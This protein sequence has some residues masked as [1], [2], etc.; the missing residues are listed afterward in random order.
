MGLHQSISIYSNK[1]FGSIAKVMIFG[2]VPLDTGLH[3]FV[4]A[5]VT[6]WLFKRKKSALFIFFILLVMAA[7]KEI[8]DYYF[9]YPAPWSEYL[10]DFLA[11]FAYFFVLLLI[12]KIK[13]KLAAQPG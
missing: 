4:G 11:N 5:I 6:I 9:H 1:I 10:S 7:S 2:V 8:F 3:I 12:R 13:K